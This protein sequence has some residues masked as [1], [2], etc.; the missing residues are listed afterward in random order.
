MPHLV[1]TITSWRRGP[2]RLRQ[3]SLG[4]TEA[5][6]GRGVEAGDAE[7]DRVADGG[8]RLPSSTPP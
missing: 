7:I 2:E 5:V 8:D 6:G 1:T 3:D 4:A